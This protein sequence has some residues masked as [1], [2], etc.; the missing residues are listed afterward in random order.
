MAAREAVAKGDE[1][2]DLFDAPEEWVK[3][4]ERLARLKE[5]LTT[6]RLGTG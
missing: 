6:E 3:E 1:D 4:G 5:L 2:A